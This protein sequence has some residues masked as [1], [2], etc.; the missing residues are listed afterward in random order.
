M[1]DRESMGAVCW[2]FARMSVGD[3]RAEWVRQ[4]RAAWGKNPKAYLIFP[5]LFAGIDPET[6]SPSQAT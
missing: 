4:A 3:E 5:E 1:E 2:S 6:E